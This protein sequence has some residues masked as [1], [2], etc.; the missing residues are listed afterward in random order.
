MNFKNNQNK[1]PITIIS[2]FLGAGKSTFLSYIL[3]ENHGKKIIVVQN[4]LGDR[5][6]LE[7][8]MIVNKGIYGT[9]E[10]IEFPNGC[11]CCT[12][13]DEMLLAVENLVKQNSNID[14]IFIETDGL[15]DPEPLVR[16]LWVDSELESSIYL[17][18]VICIVDSVF[19]LQELGLLAPAKYKNEAYRQVVFADVILLN[20]TD[21]VSCTQ[22]LENLLTKIIF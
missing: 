11:L 14:A 16:S 3:K 4:E 2:G 15:A 17:D 21:R 1:I 18:G 9:V 13:K 12:V 7:E 19:F 6:G 10:W 22:D 8:A 5:I 20:K